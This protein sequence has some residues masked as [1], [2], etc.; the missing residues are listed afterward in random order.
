MNGISATITSRQVTWRW[1]RHR[2]F[3]FTYV[4]EYFIGRH[5]LVHVVTLPIGKLLPKSIPFDPSEN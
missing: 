3:I 5:T 1:C 4:N 2:S